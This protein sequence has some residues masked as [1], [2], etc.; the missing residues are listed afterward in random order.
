LNDIA[1]QVKWSNDDSQL[2]SAA[3]GAAL[4]FRRYLTTHPITKRR[5]AV[6]LQK[7]T[8]PIGG[9]SQIQFVVRG[10]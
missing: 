10:Y 8:P 2:W 3:V 4:L 7:E 5:R 9:L 1:Q 6:A